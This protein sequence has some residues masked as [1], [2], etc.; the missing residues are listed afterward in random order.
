[1]T[2]DARIDGRPLQIFSDFDGTI[3]ERDVIMMIMEAFAPP[4]WKEITHRILEE[5]TLSIR[6]GVAELFRLIPGSKKDEII[7]FVKEEV[8]FRQG[9]PEFLDFCEDR[10]IPF[11]VLSG[12]LDFFIE[13]V[14]AP[15]RERLEI[16]CNGSDFFPEYIAVTTPHLDLDCTGC[17]QCG[18]CKVKIMNEAP[19]ET[20]RVAIGDSLTDLPMARRADWTF[21]RHQLIRYCDEEQLPYTPYETFDDIRSALTERMVAHHVH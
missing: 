2:T 12:G 10:K 14:L 5:R 15:Y 17:G 20:F 19:S 21:A 3:T 9:F 6:D 13:P 8:R 1:M 7:A 16:F 4:G 18:C 11:Q